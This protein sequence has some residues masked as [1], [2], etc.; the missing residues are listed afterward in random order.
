MF[1]F[2]EEEEATAKNA[3]IVNLAGYK[4]MDEFLQ[5]FF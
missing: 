2:F 5:I 1:F 4:C 3:A